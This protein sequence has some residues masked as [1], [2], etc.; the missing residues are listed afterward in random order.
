MKIAFKHFMLGDIM[1][2]HFLFSNI[3]HVSRYA[4]F[5]LLLAVVILASLTAGGLAAP[6]RDSVR[7]QTKAGNGA[8]FAVSLDVPGRLAQA[9]AAR[10]VL[11][12]QISSDQGEILLVGAAPDA[13][14]RVGFPMRK[15][16]E[17]V[18]GARY[19]LA[20]QR[21]GTGVIPWDSF[22][23]VLLDLGNQVL[24]RS[25]PEMAEQLPALGVKIARIPLEAQPW[26]KD[27]TIDLN[28]DM[29]GGVEN[30]LA[31]TP[32]PNVQ[33]IL[34]QVSTS[35]IYTYTA[36]LSGAQAATIGGT[37]YTITRRY[38]Y[39]GTP[40][41]KATQYITE[42]LQARGLAVDNQVW[43]T[44]GTPSTYPN[45]IGQITGTTNP[46]N[47]YIIGG[48]LDDM[49]SLSTAPGADDN[50][51]GS[52]GTLIAAEILSQ[53]QWSCTVRFAFWTGEEQGLYGSAA[54]ATR[55]KNQGENIKGYLNMDMISY[56]SGAPNEI[57][58]F[59]KSSV[60]GS[61][62][63]M[64]LYAD[65]I[66]A[67]GLNLVPVK[68]PDDTMGNYSDN[69]S[70]WD[71]GYASILAI[72]DYY[73]DE[74]PYY[75]T[76]NDKLTTLNMAYYTDFVKASL[77]TFV[78]MS[79]C[80]VTGPTP[81][82]TNS[83]TPTATA[84]ITPTPTETSIPTAT[85]TPTD[86]GTPTETPTAS[87]TPT[88]TQTPTQTNTPLPGALL[89]LGSSTAGTAGSVAFQDEDILVKNMGSGTWS[90]YIDGS[91]IGLTNTDIDA[92]EKLNDGSVLMSFDSD[93]TL[94]GFGTVDDS[95]ILRFTPTSTG[96]TTAGAWSWYFDG[97]DVGLTT[98]D[99]D[100]DAFDLLPDGRLIM[101]F[102]GNV[103]VTGVSG[104]DEDLLAFTP[105]QLGATTSGTWAWY[106]DGSDVGLSTTSNEDVNGVWVD[107]AGKVY[108]TTLG[109][110]SVTGVSGDG[111]D[112]F[113]CTPGSL[114]STTTCTWAMYWD[115]SLNGFS[116]EDT[117]S[118]SIAP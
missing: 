16:D 2:K 70:F 36:Q 42:H 112:I 115:G 6:I 77:A 8:L 48:H 63:M 68:Y 108:L 10:L 100:I 39:S 26:P 92:F 88:F 55:A 30:L 12:S 33:A 87:N 86:T 15:L 79:G 111:S 17:D 84:T 69:K 52:V 3:L 1:R 29:T 21:A 74:T 81:T 18:S 54:Y 85:F 57:N 83:S 105:S 116:G 47:I 97:S 73:G 40:I 118:I 72:E 31:I 28:A 76:S 82:P 32:D 24:L 103:S 64:N 22:G 89:Y 96:D 66:T 60:P 104:V 62:D 11:Y 23:T 27:S 4:L 49:P 78:H 38:S 90:M 53:Y 107:T 50:A 117:D 101:S 56:N 114:G 99:E 37:S 14:G 46:G 13:G 71:K 44:S 9:R 35:T 98:T 102:L 51:S 67:Y 113:T 95:D 19:Y 109:N 65:A 20:Y 59:S 80:L 110:F 7:M 93:F 94:T 106:F 91:D 45:V 25:N 58:L 41:Q 75:H 34:D 5:P 43:G 61:V